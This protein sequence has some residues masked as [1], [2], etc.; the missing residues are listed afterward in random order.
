MPPIYTAL[1]VIIHIEV[2]VLPC[3]ASRPTT[4]FQVGIITSQ[5]VVGADYVLNVCERILDDHHE[6]WRNEST[7]PALLLTGEHLGQFTDEAWDI[8]LRHKEIGE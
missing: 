5:R 6:E 8:A 7:M 4:G 2:F 3:F 1:D